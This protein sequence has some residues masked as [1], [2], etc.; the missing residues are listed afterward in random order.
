MDKKTEGVEIRRAADRNFVNSYEILHNGERVYE[1]HAIIR[2]DH[3]MLREEEDDHVFGVCDYGGRSSQDSETVQSNIKNASARLLKTA[4]EC[5]KEYA[6]V[7]GNLPIRDLSNKQ[8]K[9]SSLLHL[10]YSPQD[11]A[12]IFNR[13]N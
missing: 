2:D 13:S 12:T 4:R 6:R 8:T 10:V 9:S 11:I 3:F 1:F 5:A 7:N